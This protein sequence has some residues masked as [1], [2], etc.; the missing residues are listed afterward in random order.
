MSPI[1]V[2]T[3]AELRTELDRL[4]AIRRTLS[5]QTDAAPDDKAAA[6]AWDAATDACWRTLD[7][8]AEIP[9]ASLPDLRVKAYGLAWSARLLDGEPYYNPCP[10][11]E[12]ILRQLVAGLLDERIA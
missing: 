6:A 4:D 10:G 1:L 3:L 12:K 11:E 9:A 7:A 2:P 5:A 8:I